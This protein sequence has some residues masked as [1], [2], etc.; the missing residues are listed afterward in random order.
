MGRDYREGTSLELLWLLV[1]GWWVSA[2]QKDGE[3]KSRGKLPLGGEKGG[4][5]EGGAKG[6]KRS[7]IGRLLC[8]LSPL[9]HEE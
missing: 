5:T 9:A 6:G 1:V 7:L 3:I 8:S 4:P 2:T